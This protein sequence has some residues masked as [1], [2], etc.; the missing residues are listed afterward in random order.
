MGP[1]TGLRLPSKIWI[2]YEFSVGRGL[3]GGGGEETSSPS[4]RRARGAAHFVLRGSC[5]RG[6]GQEVMGGEGLWR[7]KMRGAVLWLLLLTAPAFG[8][9]SVPTS[10]DLWPRVRGVQ[11]HVVNL[12]PTP[13]PQAPAT[14]NLKQCLDLAFQ[15]SAGFRQNLLQL[16][17]ARQLWWVAKQQV[18]Y[19][20]TGQAEWQDLP[21]GTAANAFAAGF[22]ATWANTD[23]GTLNAL[24][25]T[26]TQGGFGDLFSETPSFTLSYDQPLLR[27]A[28][29][30][31]LHRGTPAERAQRA[32]GARTDVLRL[33]PATGA[34]APQRLLQRVPRARRSG[35]FPTIRGPGEEG[36]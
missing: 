24:L 20:A 2:G 14:L 34:D 33:L 9:G 19:V 15:H 22:G 10:P 4:P 28:G 1:R 5:A 13:S 6:R 26:G 25:S 11:S 23:G 21:G 35:Y 16:L 36:L 8:A 27:G 31:L 7:V 3:A 32:L 18:S 30:G 29:P 17:D 12:M